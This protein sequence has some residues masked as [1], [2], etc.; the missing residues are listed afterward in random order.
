MAEQA[1]DGYAICPEC[2]HHTSAC[3]AGRCTVMEP[4]IVGDLYRILTCN[5]DCYTT[6]HG[7]SLDEEIAQTLEKMHRKEDPQ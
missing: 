5:H 2:G 4:V 3:V 1:P 7:H 6:L